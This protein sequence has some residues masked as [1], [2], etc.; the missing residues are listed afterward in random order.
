MKPRTLSSLWI[1]FLCLFPIGSVSAKNNSDTCSADKPV[2]AEYKITIK[3]GRHL[4]EKMLQLSRYKQQVAIH[5]PQSNVTE[6]WEKTKNEKLHLIRIFEKHKRGIEYQ[7]SE[8]KG[9]HDWSMKQ[10]LISNIA[11]SNMTLNN[12]TGESCSL[13][14]NYSRKTTKGETQIKWLANR[15]LIHSYIEI[16]KNRKTTWILVSSNTETESIANKF[17]TLNSY[18]TTDYTDIGDNESDPFLMGMINLGFIEGHSHG[19]YDSDGNEI[20]RH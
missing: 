12:T 14:K 18:D 15:A 11:L 2:T 13:L 19:F 5:Y 9:S 10:Q 6:L 8:I 7:P 4:T 16:N 3:T 17:N 1:F 20:G